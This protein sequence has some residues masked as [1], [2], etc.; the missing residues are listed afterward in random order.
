MSFGRGR[1]GPPGASKQSVAAW[2]EDGSLLC[3]ADVLVNI[4]G[5][6]VHGRFDLGAPIANAWGLKRVWPRA[7]L[8]VVDDA[9]HAASHPGLTQE[10]I[11]ATDRFATP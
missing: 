8:V 6:L 1:S 10:L 3:D 11:H 5:I 2:I 7:E 4:P 9:G